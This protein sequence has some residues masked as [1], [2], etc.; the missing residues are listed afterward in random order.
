MDT[1]SSGVTLNRLPV[2]VRDELTDV[3]R[4]HAIWTR[5]RHGQPQDARAA[6]LRELIRRRVR[7]WG[8]GPALEELVV[9]TS[10]EGMSGQPVT[11]DYVEGLARRAAALP[12]DCPHRSPGPL[13]TAEARRLAGA[14]AVPAHPV[15]RAAHVY[16][17]CVD[18]LRRLRA[19]ETAEPGTETGGRA[20]DDGDPPWALP[21][22]LTSLVLQRADHPPLFPDP[23]CFPPPS[24]ERDP[25]A[26]FAELVH[27]FA[28]LVTSALRDEL[29]WA[30]ASVPPPRAHIPPLASVTCRRIQDYVRSRRTSL[31]L[32]LQALDPR[33]RTTVRTGGSDDAPE[34]ATAP[35]PAARTVLTPGAAHWWT[36]LELVVGDASLTLFVVVQEVGRPT[37]GVLAVTAD[38]RLT[39]PEGVRDALDMSGPESVT[40]MPSDCV[41]DRWPQMRDLVDEAV[42]RAMNVLTRV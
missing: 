14:A 25:A 41:D 21:W 32:I 3:D 2:H 7:D 12:A 23:R 17:E 6:A 29:C 31:A 10:E 40:V 11:V 9:S 39:T 24:E 35:A 4:L 19:A 28:R 37:T 27:H 15:V 8:G 5:H 13:G 22:I 36:A 38:A 16:A 18:V 20:A 33:A 34:D 42:S 30:P 26:R 1:L